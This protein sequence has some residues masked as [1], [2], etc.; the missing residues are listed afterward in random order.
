MITL[1]SWFLIPCAAVFMPGRTD[2]FSSNFS[3]AASTAPGSYF[4]ILWAFLT[5]GFFRYLI[6]RT[7]GQAGPL[8]SPGKE[9]LLTDLAVF[10]LIFSTFIP[11]LPEKRPFIS[12]IH[13]GLAFTA[14]VFFYLAI[15]IL[16]WKLYFQFPGCFSLTTGLLFFAVSMT[17]VLFLLSGFLIS[18]A[19]EV[20]LTVFA[21]L[22]LDTFYRRVKTVSLPRALPLKEGV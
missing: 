2:W 1:F 17:A 9:L 12:A 16:N 4:L 7:I 8:L 3:V 11:Y 10:L 21:S 13:V 6:R 15:T 5:G 18:S 20:F 22:W 19:L 14:T